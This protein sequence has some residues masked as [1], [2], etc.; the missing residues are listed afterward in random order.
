MTVMEIVIA[1]SLVHQSLIA[2]KWCSRGAPHSCTVQEPSKFL[3]SQTSC[4][5]LDTLQR[6][7]LHQAGTPLFCYTSGVIPLKI[8]MFQPLNVSSAR[9]SMR[10]Y[11]HKP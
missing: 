1:F 4:T 11:V 7:N 2:R 5:I 3:A 8:Y 10:M 9:V 6:S